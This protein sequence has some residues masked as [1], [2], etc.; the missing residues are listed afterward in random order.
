MDG[1][2]VGVVS[3]LR[4]D[5]ELGQ[6]AVVGVGGVE[7]GPV[8]REA[9][10]VGIIAREDHFLDEAA[11]DLGV[12]NPD[13]VVATRGIIDLA[14]IG[15][16]EAAVGIEHKSEERRVGKECVSPVIFRWSAYN[17]KKNTHEHTERYII[18]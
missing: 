7:L 17:E 14:M 18:R 3:D 10:A 6:A 11:V 13:D 12:E 16:P 5:I 2:S 8:G 15:E 1:S 4:T 9:D